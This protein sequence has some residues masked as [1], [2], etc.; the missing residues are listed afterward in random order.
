[1]FVMFLKDQC[2]NDILVAHIHA[3]GLRSNVEKFLAATITS[4]GALVLKHE[5]STASRQGSVKVL[6]QQET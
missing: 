3:I 4:E 5:F 6:L 1:M 2:H